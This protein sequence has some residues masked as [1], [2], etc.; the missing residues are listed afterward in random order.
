MPRWSPQ[1]PNAAG[2]VGVERTT[3]CGLARR[4][5]FP[6]SVIR[7]GRQL[8]VS[9]SLLLD[10][11]GS[12]D[13]RRVLMATAARWNDNYYSSPPFPMHDHGT[14]RHRVS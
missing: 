8:R 1:E 5:E 7:I 2:V 6:M 4:G 3:A 14:D 11:L 10:L 9:V 13:E 12:R